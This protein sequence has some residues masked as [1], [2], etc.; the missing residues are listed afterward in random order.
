MNIMLYQKQYI[1]F[2]IECN[3]LVKYNVVEYPKA[4]YSIYNRM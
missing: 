4:I 3:A 1:L 2:I